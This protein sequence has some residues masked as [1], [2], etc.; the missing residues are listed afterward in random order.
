MSRVLGNFIQEGVVAKVADD[1]YCGGDTPDEELLIS[2]RK[3]LCSLQKNSS[4]LSAKKTSVAP[5]STTILG[6]TWTQRK[7]HAYPHR[8]S[9]LSSCAR[10]ENVKSLRSYLG[11]YNFL[12]RV[13]PSCSSY[14]A[15]LE[16]LVGGKA[17]KDLILWSNESEEAFFASQKHPHDHRSITIPKPSDQL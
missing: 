5:K 10:P 11:A 12:S 1:L 8:I 6:W 13:I 14:L 2:W 15:P 17:S 7:L 3:V 4:A 9:T 16:S